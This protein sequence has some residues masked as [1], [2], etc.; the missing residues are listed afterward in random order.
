MTPSD[1]A[2]PW[3]FPAAQPPGPSTNRHLGPLP[4]SGLFEV[5]ARILRRHA[6][7][8]LGVAILIQLPG[9]L[10]DAVAQQRLADS[11]RPLLVGLDTETPQILAPTASQ[12]D[13]LLGTLGVVL[14]GMFVSM[15]LG[16]IAAAANA[17]TVL[18]DYHAEPTSFGGILGQA[19]RRAL[20]AIVASI[21]A[22]LALLAAV[23]LT[24]A[25]AIGA[26]VLLPTGGGEVGGLGVFLALVTGVGGAL[27][28][29]TLLIRLSLAVIAAALEDIGP[30]T[31][32]RRSWH[33]T[34]GNAW[35]TFAVLAILAFV[36]AVA[37]SL[38]VQLLGVTITDT[39]GVQLGAA[40]T[41]DAMFAA[42][43]AVLFAPV[44]IVMQTVLYLD[45]RVRRDAWDLPA[46][47]E[48]G[49]LTPGAANQTPD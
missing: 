21:L 23:A 25:L 22:A 17:T 41:L 4:I 9:A 43:V 24:A 33:L 2:P 12:S 3:S 37:G 6:P 32:L 47:G 19:L 29:V 48:D 5:G 1:P 45:L 14:L 34:G 46:P 36:T 10:L 42:A 28:A 27:V 7:I 40:D 13:L 38:V 11:V 26:A 44:T 49:D 16:A 39:V 8:L 20:P 30:V 35:R 31:A 18:R 15:V